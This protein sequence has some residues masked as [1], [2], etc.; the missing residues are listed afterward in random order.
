MSRRPPVRLT[1]RGRVVVAMACLLF[2]GAVSTASA[3]AIYATEPPATQPPA[4]ES[5]ETEVVGRTEPDQRSEPHSDSDRLSD[6][7]PQAE[8][9]VAVVLPG[10]TLWSFVARHAP[11]SDAYGIIEEVQRLNDLPDHVIHPGQELI[12]P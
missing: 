1:L 10:D 2:C 12:L 8:P 6:S 3:P 5:P 9:K 4:T 11:S 7:D